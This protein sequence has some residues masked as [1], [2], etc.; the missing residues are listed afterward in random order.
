MA[1]VVTQNQA[2]TFFF[3]LILSFYFSKDNVIKTLK[4]NF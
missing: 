4:N 2:W 3:F 1:S